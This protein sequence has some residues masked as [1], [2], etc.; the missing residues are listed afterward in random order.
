[1]CTILHITYFLWKGSYWLVAT[2]FTV[3]RLKDS[4]NWRELIEEFN[5]GKNT[6]KQFVL[7]EN[8]NVKLKNISKFSLYTRAAENTPDWSKT[9]ETLVN[10]LPEV[11]NVS[12]SYILFLEVNKTSFVVTGG[13]GYQVISSAKE[14]N[15]G[16]DL[17]SR[18]I[19]P[20]ET[21]V[22][23][24]KDRNFTG[25]ILGGDY[26]LKGKGTI[27][28]ETDFNNYFD[29]IRIELKSSVI[30]TKLGVK[31]NTKKTD[32]RFLAKDSIKLG[33]ALTINELDTLLGKVLKLQEEDGYPIN[34][35]YQV[36]KDDSLIGELN[37]KMVNKFKN[38]LEDQESVTDF[39][40]VAAYHEYD[41]QF[42]QITR[43]K[44]LI[45]D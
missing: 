39:F 18:L 38:Y 6:D 10:D 45:L 21:V 35:F 32:Y 13:S 37:N 19:E 14:F 12:H 29:E 20:S 15:F 8:K 22:K 31:I 44:V 7:K 28:S 23:G 2:H 1:M 33:K 36:N 40:I 26:Q 3:Y 11:T 4:V 5:D 25:N 34:P 41:N 30:R 9:L 16:I 17:L 42:I 43:I 24:I 27:Y